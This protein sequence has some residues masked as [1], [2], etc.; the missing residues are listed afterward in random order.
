MKQAAGC[1]GEWSEPSGS[2]GQ[3]EDLSRLHRQRLRT[4]RETP[5]RRAEEPTPFPPGPYSAQFGASRSATRGGT[6]QRGRR[7]DG[8]VEVGTV[9]GLATRTCGVRPQTR[10]GSEC[11]R[12][13]LCLRRSRPIET[14]AGRGRARARSEKD[15]PDRQVHTEGPGGKQLRQRCNG[16]QIGTCESRE[17]N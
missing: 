1:R 13:E 10:P 8:I 5:G 3:S 16:R 11:V 2:V 15:S 17:V 4:E 6:G 7:G 12:H 9:G 14:Q